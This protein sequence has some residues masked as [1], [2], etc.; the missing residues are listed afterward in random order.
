MKDVFDAIKEGD[1]KRIFRCWK[2]QFPYLRNDPGSTK[3]ALNTLGMILQAYALFSPKHTQELV[4]NKTALFKP[5]LGNN[6]PLNLLLEFFNRL[7]KEVRRK[8][9]PNTTNYKAIDRYCH[10]IDFT[11]VLHDNFDQEFCVICRPGH[12]YELSVVSD[13]QKIVSEL[14][15]QKAFCWTPGHTYEHFK[16]IDSTLLSHFDLQDMFRWINRHKR[17]IFM[18]RRAQ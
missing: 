5:G 4:W 10:A 16:A 3:Y 6:I 13:L 2:F 14:V 18:E 17:N 7:L 9:G 8:V 12:H 1:G 11:K 15:I